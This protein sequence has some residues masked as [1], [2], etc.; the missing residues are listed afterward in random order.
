[1]SIQ[2]TSHLKSKHTSNKQSAD[3]MATR[4]QAT[5]KG[6]VVL[7]NYRVKDEELG[8]I[9]EHQGKY[10]TVVITKGAKAF[11]EF[12]PELEE[13]PYEKT[14][15]EIT[16]VEEESLTTGSIFPKKQHDIDYDKEAQEDFKEELKEELKKEIIAELKDD[17]MEEIAELKHD[18]NEL[19]LEF[20]REI[21]MTRDFNKSSKSNK[22]N[23]KPAQAPVTPVADTTSPK[24]PAREASKSVEPSA[25]KKKP[26]KKE[27]VEGDGAV[28]ETSKSTKKKDKTA[29]TTSVADSDDDAEQD[30]SK[31]TATKGKS[32]NC[33]NV[34]VSK[35]IAELKKTRPDLI[36]RERVT[37]ANKIWSD[38]P[39]HEKT[40][41]MKK[42]KEEQEASA[43]TE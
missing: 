5:K 19:R 33:Y 26:I 38:I 43:G 14:Q 6:I 28:A 20:R 2:T 22:S 24:K 13:D 10:Y 40:E 21:E 16:P 41:M 27:T 1:M 15:S 4:K 12:V 7:D 8:S 18:L 9:I 35:T 17:I 37:E 39:I 42:F 23:P 36:G 3:K 30:K 11:V 32:S 31:S 34:F 25:T 29:S